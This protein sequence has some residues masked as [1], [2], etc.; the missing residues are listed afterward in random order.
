MEL[1]KAGALVLMALDS[2][3]MGEP[4]GTPCPLLTALANAGCP[5]EPTAV[6]VCVPVATAAAHSTKQSQHSRH[7]TV[8]ARL[9][10]SVDGACQR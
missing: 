10:E 2:E 1:A 8:K 7:S 9:L 4:G 6:A 3:V 5:G